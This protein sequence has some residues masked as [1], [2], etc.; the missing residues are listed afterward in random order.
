[1]QR[2]FYATASDLRPVFAHVEE[3]IQIQY[4]LTGLFD[5][6]DHDAYLHGLDLP[7]LELPLLASSAIAGP[8]Y[9]VME[10]SCPVST[11]TIH[12]ENGSIKYAIDQLMNP[13]SV[14][15]LHGGFYS[16]DI[17]LYGRVATSSETVVAIRLQRA[18][19]AALAKK[20][21][22][23]KSYFV[24]PEA[25]TLLNSGIRLAIGGESP[26]DFDLA[27]D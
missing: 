26:P 21:V 1:M 5:R 25:L 12:Q 18:F 19:L 24:G 17:L 2:H 3:K 9:L 10:R 22:K 15:F 7:T 4:M 27:L 20:F 23:V 11:R 14:T 16:T 13:D 8:C 6:P